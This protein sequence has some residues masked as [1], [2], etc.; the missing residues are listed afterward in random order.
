MSTY[1]GT[2]GDD[3]YQ[4]GRDPHL[5]YGFAGNDSL[6]GGSSNDTLYG[7]R[8]SDRLYG[9][10]G[11]DSLLGGYGRDTLDGY[12]F[13]VT[14]I[15]QFDTLTGGSGADT[16]VL[17]MPP[18][19]GLPS[20]PPDPF[21]VYYLGNGYA[22]ITDFSRNQDD[23]IQIAGSLSDYSLVQTQNLSGG[24][25]NDTAIYYREDLIGVVQDTVQISLLEDFVIA[26]PDPVV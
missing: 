15:P 23:K 6:Y 10:A 4:F 11:S 22:T 16:F 24:S 21:F 7:N 1:Y 26:R 14:N 9:N 5:V 25:V 12:G 18:T 17:A 20:T 2:S 13:I 8:G 19:L 3:F